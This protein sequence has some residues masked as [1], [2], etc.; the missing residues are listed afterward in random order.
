[1]S[2]GWRETSTRVALST[3]RVD[4]WWLPEAHEPHGAARRLLAG[5]LGEP[6]SAIRFRATPAGKPA[7]ADARH[8]HLRFSFA[9]SGAHTLLA[10]RLRYDVGVDLERIRAGVDADAVVA[11]TFPPSWRV[12]WRTGRP[13]DRRAAFFG[14]WV[15]FEALAKASGRGIACDDPLAESSG[16]TCRALPTLPGFAAAVASEGRDWALACHRDVAC[17]T[18]EVAANTL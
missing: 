8:A 18:R 6:A 3:D 7:L 16:F 9:H 2:T 4:V 17:A 5:C 13:G 12:A 11:T 10:V 15:R 14:A 1:V